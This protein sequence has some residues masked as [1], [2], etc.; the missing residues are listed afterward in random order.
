MYTV[1]C[2]YVILHVVHLVCIHIAGNKY[3]CNCTVAESKY[4]GMIADAR[5]SREVW[6]NIDRRL[7]L[8]YSCWAPILGAY[9][10]V[11]LA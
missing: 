5:G 3:K 6:D 10:V 1:Y 2:T 11:L 4:R 8:Y 7:T 9:T